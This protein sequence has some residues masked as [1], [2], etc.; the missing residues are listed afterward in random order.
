MSEERL[1]EIQ[2]VRSGA[3]LSLSERSTITYE[4]YGDDLVSN[5][6][7]PIQIRVFNVTDKHRPY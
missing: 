5:G 3:T 7:L 2:V 1:Q 4:N 6:I